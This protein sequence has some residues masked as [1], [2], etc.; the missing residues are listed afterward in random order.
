ML[1]SAAMLILGFSRIE[2]DKVF[3]LIKGGSS[4]S[5]SPGFD[6]GK[7]FQEKEQQHQLTE[8]PLYFCWAKYKFNFERTGCST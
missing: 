2:D 7:I 1:Y 8:E 6:G 5:L 4:F 3:C